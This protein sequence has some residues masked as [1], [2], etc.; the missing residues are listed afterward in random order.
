MLRGSSYHRFAF[1]LLRILTG[2]RLE[3]GQEDSFGDW[4][5]NVEPRIIAKLTQ[6]Y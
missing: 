4:Q 3:D 6:G 2:A 5:D 1:I